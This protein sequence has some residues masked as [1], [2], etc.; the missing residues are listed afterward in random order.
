[1]EMIIERLRE[2]SEKKGKPTIETWVYTDTGE[3]V[4][5]LSFGDIKAFPGPSVSGYTPE[6]IVREK[7]NLCIGIFE[8]NTYCYFNKYG[9]DKVVESFTLDY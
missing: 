8:N 3:I 1:M 4:Y 2:F 5:V 7:N 6:D 9:D